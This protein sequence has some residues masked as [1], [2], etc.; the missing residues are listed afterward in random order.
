MLTSLTPRKS[1]STP[2]L[3][4]SDA[5][6][7]SGNNEVVL[8]NISD[9]DAKHSSESTYLRTQGLIKNAPVTPVEGNSTA[10]LLPKFRSK[11]FPSSRCLK[12][13]SRLCITSFKIN[14]CLTKNKQLSRILPG[15]FRFF[16]MS[17]ALISDKWQN[18][19]ASCAMSSNMAGYAASDNE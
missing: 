15:V 11:T 2:R 1:L 4:P 18:E 5:N 7:P 14:R 19:S 13:A 12:S 9:N 16:S 8:L 17:E 3:T 6:K 10:L